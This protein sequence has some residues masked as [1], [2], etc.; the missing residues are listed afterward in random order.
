MRDAPG[1]AQSHPMAECAPM[2]YPTFTDCH[3]GPDLRAA[4]NCR[5]QRHLLASFAIG[6]VTGE[7]STWQTVQALD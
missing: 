3:T 6:V 1:G 4:G 5:G 2:V 7:V